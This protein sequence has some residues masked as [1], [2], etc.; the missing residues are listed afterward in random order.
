ME[1]E[2]SERLKR[3][4]KEKNMTQQELADALGVSNKS[5][6]RWES[7][8]GYPDVPLLVPLARALGVSVD[9]LL[10]G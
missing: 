4:R 5:I 8:G 7:S 2:F 10:D 1:A 3:Y 9:D 6:S